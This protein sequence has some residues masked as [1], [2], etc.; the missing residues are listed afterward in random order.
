[1]LDMRP[2]HSASA[3]SR[4][5]IASVLLLCQCHHYESFWIYEFQTCFFS[6]SLRRDLTEGTLSRDPPVSGFQKL[7]N[8]LT[9]VVV[10]GNQS[11][12]DPKGDGNLDR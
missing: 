3:G 11:G 12:I 7:N 8:N 10:G 6:T 4:K 1:M 5:L 2:V 9:S